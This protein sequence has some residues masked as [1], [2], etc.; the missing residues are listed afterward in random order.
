MDKNVKDGP[1]I[2]NRDL[3]AAL[4]ISNFGS[5]P[6]LF[7]H[8]VFSRQ[9]FFPHFLGWLV[10]DYGGGELWCRVVVKQNVIDFLFAIFPLIFS[11]NLLAFLRWRW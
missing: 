5:F 4:L 11:L 7:P 9:V 6:L 3:L 1:M 8:C 10:G 2:H